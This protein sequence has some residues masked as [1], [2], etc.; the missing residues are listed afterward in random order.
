MIYYG[1]H[2]ISKKDILHVEKTLQS[3]FLTQGPRVKIFENKFSQKVSSKYSIACSTGT[4]AL[5][6]ACQA[7][8]L[9]KNDT[10]WTTPITFVASVN[11]SL[12][13]GAKVDFVDID[14]DD[15]NIDVELLKNKLKKTIKKKLPKILIVVHLGGISCD[16]R[17][18]FRL[19][20][21]YNFKIIEDACHGLGGSYQNSTIGSCKYSDISTFSFHPVKNMT[22]GEGGAVTTNS[23]KIY[24]KIKLLVH[25]GIS[26]KNKYE[27]D[28]KKISNN[29]RLSDMSCAL[30][31]SQLESLSK[32]IKYRKDVS[33]YY[34]K[35]ITSRTVKKRKVNFSHN[36]GYHLHIIRSEKIKNF[37]QKKKIFEI[38]EKKKIILGFHYIPI[39]RFS[40]LKDKFDFKK[41]LESEKYFKEAFSLPIYYGLKRKDQDNIIKLIN[42]Y[43]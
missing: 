25:H 37:K 23:K 2:F 35:K 13:C 28:V 38:F 10:V 36:S 14:K 7:L 29:Y 27:Y 8:E 11:S 6:L 26:R 40:I 33:N 32:F 12:L 3:N 4:S 41:F 1:K 18:I 5:H 21:K 43:L 20:K 17:K 39:Y 19:S 42:N 9:K 30:G 34:E 15:W 24:N 22:T 31:I 16:M